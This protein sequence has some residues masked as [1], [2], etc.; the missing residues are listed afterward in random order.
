MESI[1]SGQLQ[2]SQLTVSAF[3]FAVPATEA[4]SPTIRVVLNWPAVL[5]KGPMQ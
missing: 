2:R 5:K 4:P 1:W 3:L